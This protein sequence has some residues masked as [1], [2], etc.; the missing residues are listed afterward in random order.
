MTI[1]VSGGCKN[2][3]SSL[4]EDWI[5]ALA[6]PGRL[7]YL[8]TMIPHDEE[9]LVRIRRHVASRAGKGF[10][11]IECT[12]SAAEPALHADPHGSFLLDSVTA[13]LSNAM[14]PPGGYNP[15]AGLQVAEDLCRLA[16]EAK[17]AVFVSDFIYSDFGPYDPYTEAYRRALAD[18]DRALAAACDTVVEV[19]LAN[20]LIYKG[21]LPV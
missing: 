10:Q 1:F 20:P 12:V 14:F 9:D 7:Y 19:S 3:K 8:A 2:G 11:T 16:R 18:C 13:L 4:A 5:G 21:V 6:E 15:D 17:N